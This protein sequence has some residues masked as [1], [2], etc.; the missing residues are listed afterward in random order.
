MTGFLQ[1]KGNEEQVNSQQVETNSQS[2]ESSSVK[3]SAK[4]VRT[5]P[6]HLQ[7][8]HQH[9]RNKLAQ[10]CAGERICLTREDSAS[11]AK[12]R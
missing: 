12:Y 7:A 8:C 10:E 11:G 4:A 9:N 3:E 1:V 6:D 2:C 5:R